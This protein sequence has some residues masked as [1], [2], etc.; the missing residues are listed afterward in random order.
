MAHLSRNSHPLI[1]RISHNSTA[2]QKFSPFKQKNIPKIGHLLETLT[3]RTKEYPYNSTSLY[4]PSPFNRKNISRISH[5]PRNSHPS[6]ERISPQQYSSLEILTLQ[7][8][9][10]P[11][12]RTSPQKL[13]PFERKSIPI[14]AHLSRNSHPLIERMSL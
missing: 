3:I 10:Y 8:K 4:K 5:L 9:E 1:E 12:N 6:N 2:P 11:Y 7:T 13:S 14:I